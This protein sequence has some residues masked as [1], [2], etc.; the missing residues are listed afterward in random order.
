[1]VCFVLLHLIAISLAPPKKIPRHSDH[2]QSEDADVEVRD[3]PGPTKSMVKK[4]GKKLVLSEYEATVLKKRM[5]DMYDAVL[6]YQVAVRILNL[7]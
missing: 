2:A 7:K 4:G 1:M 6:S 3:S 5:R